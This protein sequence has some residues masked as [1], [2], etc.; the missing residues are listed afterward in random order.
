MSS[1]ENKRR[2]AVSQL[3]RL[4]SFS[5]T[6][7]VEDIAKLYPPHAARLR[8]LRDE[9]KRVIEQLANRTHVAGRIAGAVLGHL[10]TVVRLIAGVVEKAGV[11]TKHGSP[12]LSNRIGMM[13]AR[14]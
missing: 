11:Y 5:G 4:H 13:D 14:G 7:R 2:M 12:Q 3:T 9:L 1:L 8:K 10:N 6:M